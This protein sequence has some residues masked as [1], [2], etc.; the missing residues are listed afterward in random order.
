MKNV[1]KHKLIYLV[2]YNP[3]A[4]DKFKIEP[5]EFK[6]LSWKHPLIKKA[7]AIF[8]DEEYAKQFYNFVVT[9][10]KK[11]DE[12]NKAIKGE[13]DVILEEKDESV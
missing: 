11:Q 6:S 13:P 10:V 5:I 9:N 7:G 8:A 3:N 1:Q 12:D 4:E 2:V